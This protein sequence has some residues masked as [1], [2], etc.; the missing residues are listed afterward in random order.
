[1][2]TTFRPRHGLFLMIFAIVGCA[3]EP[4]DTSSVEPYNEILMRSM[5]D[6]KNGEEIQMR[7]ILFAPGW[8]APA[9]ITTAIYSSM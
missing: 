4:E 5:L 6:I 9:T 1:M 7:E 3:N 2:S 8:K